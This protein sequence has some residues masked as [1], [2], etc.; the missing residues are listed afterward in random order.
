MTIF[1]SP[2]TGDVIQPTDVSYAS[3][4]FSANVQLY[5]PQYIA[6]SGQQV[7]ARIMEF[8]A[9]AAGLSVFLPNAQQTSVGQDILIRNTGANSFVVNRF[10]GGGSFTVAAGQSFYTYLINNTTTAGIWAVLQFG[11][12]TSSADANTLAGVSTAAIAGKLE[13]ALVTSEYSSSAPTITDSQR[14]NCLVW[15]GGLSTWTLPPVTQLST[16]W[17]ILV[18]NNGTG[19]LTIATSAVGST[20]DGLVNIVLPLGDSCFICVNRDPAK[21]DF[22][23]VGRARPNSLTFTSAT[24]DVDTIVGATY[25]LVSN[26]PIIQRYTALSGSRTTS[27]LIQ[28]PAVTQVY[29]LINNTNQS[30]YN[31]NFQ[32]QG[33]SQAPIALTNASQVI[34]L[35]DGNFLYPLNQSSTGQQTVADGTVAAPAYSFLSDST[36]GMYLANP[37]Q[38]GFSTGGVNILT[39]DG[40]GGA[41]NF[42]S[43]F[44]GRVQ[45][46]LIAGGTF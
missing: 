32:V 16:G 15:T 13:A 24:Y 40:S 5:W 38:L 8:T 9:T 27:L 22:F 23:T 20:I 4:S 35:S 29:Y 28:L 39:L 34:M 19:A 17:F 46:T 18:R 2:F 12:G 6:T 36:T 45:A 31:I 25:S 3:V 30:G 7:A 10:G 43:R 14:G 11:T 21:Q 26:T 44:V 37:T 1:V 33:S 41:G 42:V